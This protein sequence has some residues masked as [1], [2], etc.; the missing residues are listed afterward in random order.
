M[1]IDAYSFCPGGTGKKIKFC[2]P[3]FLGELE[4][5][6]RMLEGEQFLGCLNHVEAL[7]KKH[8]DK[9]C[10]LAERCFLF[11]ATNRVDELKTASAEFL[12]KHPGNPIALAEH[13]MLV[14]VEESGRAAMEPMQAALAAC[15]E[16]H[17]PLQVYETIWTVAQL[18][19]VDGDLIA[20]RAWTSLLLVI[21][22]ADSRP[23]ELL[24]R[25][26]MSPQ[27]PLWAKDEHN[28]ADCPADAPWKNRFDEAL[29]PMRLSQWSEAAERLAALAKEIPDAPAIWRSLATL[30]AWTA[31]DA[32]AI[33]S[34][35]TF[36]ALDVPLEDAVEAEALAMYL[37]ESPLGDDVSV[38]DL[39]LAVSD[40]DAL[41]ESL[42]AAGRLSRVAVDSSRWPSEEGPPPKAVY[43]LA[44]R[45]DPEPADLQ[46]ADIPRVLSQIMLFGRETDRAA[47]VE[48]V[49]LL[50]VD[51]TAAQ[52]Y[53]A[54]IGGAALGA[55]VREENVAKASQTREV[56]MPHWRLPPWIQSEQVRQLV[57]QYRDHA[58]FERW[59]K[60]P[61]GCL[62]GR[63]PQEAASDPQARVRVLAAVLL[64][65]FFA[66][67]VGIRVDMNRLRRQ[68]GLPELGPIDPGQTPIAEVP[69]S[70]QAR[71]E[72]DK[73]ADEALT[74]AFQRATVLG[75][76]EAAH[77]FAREIVGRPAFE[78]RPE[79]FQAFSLLIRAVRDSDQALAWIDRAR[80]EIDKAGRSN[81]SIDIME[82]AE[83]FKRL[84]VQEAS[85]LM[86]HIEQKHIREPG[87]AVGPEAEMPA[88]DEAKPG[89]LWVPDAAKSAA[90]EKSKLWMPGMD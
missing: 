57:Q 17:L 68:F 47:R 79:R 43:A 16:E 4:T 89:E 19:A 12:A 14:A 63:A 45:P 11:R 36:A 70:R 1:P 30:Q 60:L 55:V 52:A 67:G 28:P 26:D 25:L 48:V 69:L 35:R 46:I 51:R 49:R 90:A 81:A 84:E 88:V 53:L 29:S 3:D 20:A 37:S 74:P 82:L 78:G 87:V 73:L 13:A 33:A 86:R 71:I 72:A 75:A 42:A 59:P 5:I 65:E 23:S 15:T 76:M 80:G 24:A 56:L 10:L 18:L 62:G 50:D 38:W 27:F 34:L 64:L 61:L 66:G 22:D 83:R 41:S 8:P 32:G 40:V 31:D 7:L 39:T 85:R 9:A 77:R 21:H 2:C 44:D 6:Q 58:I 54:Q